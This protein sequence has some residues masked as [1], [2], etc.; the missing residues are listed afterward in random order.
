MKKLLERIRWL[1]SGA[2]RDPGQAFDWVSAPVATLAD[3]RAR[4]SIAR[5]SAALVVLCV[6][7]D[8][9]ALA[10]HQW[11]QWPWLLAGHALWAAAFV[12]GARL[13]A[14]H[15]ETIDG[16][17]L[18][19]LGGPN[20]ITLA[21]A[22][23]IP[24]LVYLIAARDFRVSAIAYAV[25]VCSD[26]VDGYW[27]R[28][29]K[30]RTKFGI[31]LDPIADL[32]LH[33]AVFLCLGIVKLLPLLAAIF[34]AARSL[35]LIIGVGVLRFHKG[36]VRIQ[37]TPFGKATGLLQGSATILLLWLAGGEPGSAL[38]TI[39]ALRSFLTVLL[40]LLVLHAIT[41]GVINLGWRKPWLQSRSARSRRAAK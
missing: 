39:G 37:P 8:L 16:R 27:A 14:V 9:A 38:R 41:I 3:P 40:G 17:P 20:S 11:W 18:R 21:R 29:G 15:L 7:A 34:I 6:I 2:E 26:V 32:F 36:S 5:V 4:S 30:L 25:L 22:M 33:L 23:L 31:V 28:V 12:T 1:A 10:R 13:S 24:A 35:I 19:S